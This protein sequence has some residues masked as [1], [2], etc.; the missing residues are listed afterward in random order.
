[1]RNIKNKTNC[2]VKAFINTKDISIFSLY[3]KAGADI[4]GVHFSMAPFLVHGYENL[5]I[6]KDK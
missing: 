5:V 4:V 2:I 1:M 3:P 6:N